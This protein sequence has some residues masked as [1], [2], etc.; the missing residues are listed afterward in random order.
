[1]NA[2]TAHINPSDVCDKITSGA[3][4]TKAELSVYL[5]I[6][7]AT[8]RSWPWLPMI[9]GLLFYD[10]FIAARRLHLGLEAGQ[11]NGV[12]PPKYGAGKFEKSLSR[13][14]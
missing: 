5:R 11:R 1:M 9:G 10:D 14:D 7:Y 2:R 8:V 6:A 3:P 13:H 4:I 12:R